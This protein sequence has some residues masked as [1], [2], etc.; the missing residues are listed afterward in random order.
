MRTNIEIDQ[1]L[2][3]EAMRISGQKTKK[4]TVHAALE[5]M[6]KMNR[7]KAFAEKMGKIEWEGN[8]D[9]WRKSK[10]KD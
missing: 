4:A 2:L 3:M 7:R 10:W 6:V 5:Q 8:L 9:E 1:E